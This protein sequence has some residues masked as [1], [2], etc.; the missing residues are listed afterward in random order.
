MSVVKSSSLSV[1]RFPEWVS[2]S[3]YNPLTLSDVSKR[4]F[5]SAS[6]LRIDSF[7]SGSKGSSVFCNAARLCE[8]AFL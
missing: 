8:Y 5:V 3:V 7:R 6:E 4:S 1:S 2:L